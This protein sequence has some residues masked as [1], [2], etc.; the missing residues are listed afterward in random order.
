MLTYGVGRGKRWRLLQNLTYR[1]YQFSWSLFTINQ[2]AKRAW[3]IGQEQECRLFYLAYEDCYQ[4]T[5]AE[6]IA[7]KNRATAAINGDVSS[8]GLSAMLGDEGDLQTMLIQSVKKG[9]TALKGSAEEWI[10]QTSDR[11][12]ELL[13]SIGKKKKA[14]PIEQF[15]QWVNSE[16]EG[17]TTK[18][19]LIRGAA[20]YLGFIEQDLIPGFSLQNG[21]LNV[22]LEEG[23]GL[24]RAFFGDGAILFH[25]SKP[26]KAAQSVAEEKEKKEVVPTAPIVLTTH[27]TKTKR[28]KK[29]VA[30]GQWAF[31]LFG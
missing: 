19:T 29:K 21:Q 13:A 1:H 25:L 10:N 17:E 28:A 11:A 16:I 12:R 22:D 2:S 23:T 8:D 3:R 4:E 30:E 31:D 24:D 15:K 14:A 27:E 9:G 7:K 18:A 6:L 26:M 5:M 20:E